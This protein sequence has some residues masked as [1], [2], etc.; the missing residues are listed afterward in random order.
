MEKFT[1]KKY[2]PEEG[3]IVDILYSQGWK[4]TQEIAEFVGVQ[5]ATI[6]SWDRN[7]EWRQ[8]ALDK[9]G[10]TIMYGS[11]FDLSEIKR[12]RDNLNSILKGE[13]EEDL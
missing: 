2:I 11:G 12:I 8:W 3:T 10:F 6:V 1:G 9:L 5:R 7:F 4:T 13:N